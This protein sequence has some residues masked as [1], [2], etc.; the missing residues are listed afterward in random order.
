MVVVVWPPS[1]LEVELEW[2]L[3]VCAA[4][5]ERLL[6][7]VSSLVERAV[8]DKVGCACA[9]L[10]SRD[11]DSDCDCSGEAATTGALE[12]D[13]AGSAWRAT[14]GSVGWSTT[15]TRPSSDDDK[16]I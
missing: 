6:A 9:A 7:A 16:L 11:C 3:V 1:E 12:S 15:R 13:A 5:V 2:P 8:V 4:V 10:P 14:G